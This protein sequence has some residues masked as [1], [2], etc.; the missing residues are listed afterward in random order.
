MRLARR[1]SATFKDLPGGQILGPTYDY[2][3]RL[4]DF[5]LQDESPARRA[6]E[7]GA[8]SPAQ[9]PGV[10]D[11]L[12]AEGLVEAHRAAAGDPDPADL[13]REP[14]AF[15]A[16]RALRL[17]NLARGDEGFLL[18]MGYSTQR[19]YAHSHPF[20]GEIRYGRVEVEMVPDELGFAVVVG[21]IALTECQMVN[22]FAGSKTEPPQFTR[23][24]GLAFGQC[25]RKSM[26]MALVD[27]ALRAAEL[28]EQAKAPAQMQEF[29]LS[30]SD[31]V[32]ASGFVQHLKLPH[33]V[34]FQSELELVRGMRAER[35]QAA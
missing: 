8:P 16:D 20:A 31:N 21:E 23:G 1:I 30:H 17:Q 3:Q 35:G 28:G 25:E 29:V 6:P 4:L 32:E 9:A 11:L 33:Y 19:G 34:D 27:R 7:A 22:Q 12:G 24:Y 18:A 26:V 13:T 15:P 2:T 14:I 10:I 5:S